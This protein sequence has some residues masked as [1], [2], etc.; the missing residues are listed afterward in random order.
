MQ[1]HR[2]SSSERNDPPCQWQRLTVRTSSSSLE[3]AQVI[4]PVTNAVEDEGSSSNDDEGGEGVRRERQQIISWVSCGVGEGA[5]ADLI[6]RSA[7]SV[8]RALPV[9][10]HVRV[11]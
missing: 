10:A 7:V 5:R 4:G 2:N 3:V 11:I 6:D 8:D 1:Q 9:K